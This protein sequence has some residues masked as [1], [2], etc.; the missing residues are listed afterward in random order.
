F[1][2][3]QLGDGDQDPDGRELARDPFL[4]F[5]EEIERLDEESLVDRFRLPAVEAE[6]LL[7][8]LLV[9]RALLSETAAQRLVVTDA[10]LRAGVVLEA[11]EPKSRLS[12]EDF[13]HQVLA[14]ADTLGRRYRF[15]R[16]HGH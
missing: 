9:Y 2:A 15:D 5:C 11:A 14:S 13:A 7:P 10:T 3:S 4:A 12:A 8:A 1:A 16:D 6:T